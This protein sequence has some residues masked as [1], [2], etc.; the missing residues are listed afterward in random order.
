[1]EDFEK[2]TKSDK[3][4]ARPT[5][6]E[7]KNPSKPNQEYNGIITANTTEILRITRDYYE[8]L[9]AM[10]S[11]LQSAQ[12]MHTQTRQWDWL[13]EN[14][15]AFCSKNLDATDLSLVAHSSYTVFW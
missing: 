3:P 9:Y 14:L 6:K 10:K 2:I 7:G 15:D 1:M 13:W 8:N 12:K 11:G 5:E 4:L